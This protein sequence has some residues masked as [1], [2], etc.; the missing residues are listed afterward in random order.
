MKCTI[1]GILAGLAFI[2]SA[3]GQSCNTTTLQINV[4]TN[5]DNVVLSTY[6]YCGGTLNTTALINNLA[7]NKQVTLYY[8]DRE[9]NGTPLSLIGLGYEGSINGTNYELW[10][11]S[12]PAYV[13]GVQELLNL[14]IVYSDLGTALL[15]LPSPDE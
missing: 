1:V 6:S 5:G 10:S 14:T 12:S 7:Y 2:Q 9:G 15:G 4:P 13:D 11:S 8:T 3:H